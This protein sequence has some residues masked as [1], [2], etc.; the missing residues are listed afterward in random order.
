MHEGS[1]GTKG[2]IGNPY[3]IKMQTLSHTAKVVGTESALSGPS[4]IRR[5]AAIGQ[6]R[7]RTFQRLSSRGDKWRFQAR[8]YRGKR[9]IIFNLTV[10]IT[11]AD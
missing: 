2:A 5:E 9:A 4:P 8:Q 1:V 7:H 10:H 11:G 6:R 3:G